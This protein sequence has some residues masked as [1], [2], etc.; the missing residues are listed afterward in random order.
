MPFVY[1][2]VRGFLSPIMAGAAWCALFWTAIIAV[3][4]TH[5][6]HRL[7]RELDQ[8][9]AEVA[10]YAAQLNTL[11][12]QSA[13]QAQRAKDAI[14][15]IQPQVIHDRKVITVIQAAKPG[16]DLCESAHQLIA[17]TFKGDQ[18]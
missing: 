14:A 15:S 8:A 5:N 13:D 11:A 12:V 18:Q 9:K 1:Q 4:A 3:M 10:G 16:P 17:Q 2:I 6:A 7:N